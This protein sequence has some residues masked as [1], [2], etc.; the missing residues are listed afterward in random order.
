LGETLVT[1]TAPVA[2]SL[3]PGEGTI[4]TLA[5]TPTETGERAAVIH[6]STFGFLAK[7]GN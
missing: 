3:E 4:F 7:N 5:F 2:G 6:S 1:V